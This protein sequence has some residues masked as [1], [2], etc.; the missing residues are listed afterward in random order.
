M[1]WKTWRCLL[2]PKR[3]LYFL[4]KLG[5]GLVWPG[6]L[7]DVCLFKAST[8]NWWI[9]TKMWV[10]GKFLVNCRVCVIY[11]YSIFYVIH[12]RQAV[13]CYDI[14]YKVTTKALGKTLGPIIYQ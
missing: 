7:L 5:K 13:Y 6:L 14:V 2:P 9:D 10:T 12:A 11:I 1:F 8:L 3:I 4:Q